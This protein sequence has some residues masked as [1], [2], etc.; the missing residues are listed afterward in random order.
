MNTEEEKEPYR[1]LIVGSGE[2]LSPRMKANVAILL[3]KYPDMEIEYKHVLSPDDWAEEEAECWIVCDEYSQMDESV[4]NNMKLRCP[5]YYPTRD[6]FK[7]KLNT[8]PYYR[9][10]E[11]Y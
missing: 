7:Q 10:K 5:T 4:F 3:G 8:K 9:Q 1:L 6:G 2:D 11:R